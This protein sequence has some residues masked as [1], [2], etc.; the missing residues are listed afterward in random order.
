MPI[1]GIIARESLMTWKPG[2]HGSTFGGNPVAAVSALATL[3][4]IERE[5]VM[6]QATETGEFIM[7]ALAEMEGRHPSL[8][9]IRGRG[10]MIGM[11][12]VKDRETKERAVDLRNKVIQNAF[13]MG[14][15]LI[16]CGANSIRMTPPLNIEQPL[17]EEGLSIFERAL[18]AAESQYMKN[19]A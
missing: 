7:S 4:V 9:Q 18:T 14:L 16:P 17:V 13:E 12:F 15:L 11:E 8:G 6:D 1:G 10:L 5:G 2:S 3:E 19:G